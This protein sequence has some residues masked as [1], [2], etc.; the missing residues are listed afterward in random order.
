MVTPI[1]S[2]E[3]KRRGGFG[4]VVSIGG[5]GYKYYDVQV[6]TRITTRYRK[7]QRQVKTF[8]SGRQEF[9]DWRVIEEWNTTS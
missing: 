8:Y 3:R 5:S 9:G 4:R 2:R 1:M 6:G 7:E